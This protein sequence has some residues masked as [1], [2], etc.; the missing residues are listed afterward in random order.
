MTIPLTDG[1]GRLA[2][3]EITHLE[4]KKATLVIR[5]LTEKPAPSP[6]VHLFVAPTKQIDRMEWLVEKGT[7]IGVAG[8]HFFTSYHSERRVIRKD[9][10]EQIALAAMKQSNRLHLPVIHPLIP[11]R[12]ALVKAGT[13]PVRLIAQAGGPIH[14]TT[15]AATKA[16]VA[17]LIGPEGDFSEQEIQEALMAGF[18]KVQL[19]EYRLRTET[20]ALIAAALIV[21]F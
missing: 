9:R 18:T 13:Y 4:K 8:F 7:E 15:R 12:D 17:L 3:A 21:P 1:A 2:R 20:A 10:L 19:G 16:P 6:E 11:W 5:E 14:L